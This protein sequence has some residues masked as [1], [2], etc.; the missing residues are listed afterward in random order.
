[1]LRLSCQGPHLGIGT[2]IVDARGTNMETPLPN[3]AHPI[4]S[5]V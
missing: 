2:R 4:T 3:I 1:M 5:C